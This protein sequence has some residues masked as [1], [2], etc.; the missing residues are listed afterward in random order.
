VRKEGIIADKILQ[1]EHLDINVFPK[2]RLW[3]FF[4]CAHFYDFSS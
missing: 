1:H 2:D 4:F 3:V